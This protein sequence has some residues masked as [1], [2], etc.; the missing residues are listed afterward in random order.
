[1]VRREVAWEFRLRLT[2]RCKI[3]MLLVSP[4]PNLGDIAV[5]DLDFVVDLVHGQCRTGCRRQERR[6]GYA[7]ET[8]ASGH[9]FNSLPAQACSAGVCAKSKRKQTRRRSRR[10]SQGQHL[11]DIGS[12]QRAG[13][14]FGRR[15]LFETILSRVVKWKGLFQPQIQLQNVDA[16][17]TEDK[18][19][20]GRP[21]LLDE[22]LYLLRRYATR[23]CDPC[24]LEFG[25]GG[26]VV[27]AREHAKPIKRDAI[28]E[29]F[30][31]TP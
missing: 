27:V 12:G 25:I 10:Q 18:Q 6:G 29:R 22:R 13:D 16:W 9:G 31:N 26:S 20:A 5:I 23:P 11:A 24:D 2:D 21:M 17:L 14:D 15:L 28:T 4:L 19:A 1:M 8:A 3:E 7:S 30:L